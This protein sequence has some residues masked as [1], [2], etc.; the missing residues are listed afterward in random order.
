MGVRV[1]S[2]VIN[3][4]NLDTMSWFLVPSP[5]VDYRTSHRRARFRVFGGEPMNLSLQVSTAP[6]P[7]RNQIHS[8][9]TPRIRRPKSPGSS[10]WEPSV[11]R[12]SNHPDKDYVVMADPEDNLFCFCAVAQWVMAP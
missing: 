11:V 2:V 7:G 5:G 1:G 10:P 8:I 6:T 4:K 12:H 3:C 9:S